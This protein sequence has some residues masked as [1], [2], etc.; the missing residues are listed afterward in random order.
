MLFSEINRHADVRYLSSLIKNL[1][2][3]IKNINSLLVE[4]QLTADVPS[5]LPIRNI[6]DLNELSTKA[7]NDPKFAACLVNLKIT[8]YVS[9]LL[10]NFRN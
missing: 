6:Q 2:A 1:Q 10:L 5:N 8:S 9:M 3:K 7:A 4:K